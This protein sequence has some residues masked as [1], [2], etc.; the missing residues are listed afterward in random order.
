MEAS[1]DRADLTNAVLEGANLYATVGFNAKRHGVQLKGAI[2]DE[3]M[4]FG[5][6]RG[7]KP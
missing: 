6:R 1:F 5:G 3:S 7:R 2:V 4:L